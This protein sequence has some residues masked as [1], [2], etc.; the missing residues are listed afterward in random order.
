MPKQTVSTPPEALLTILQA[1]ESARLALATA[2]PERQRLGMTAW[3]ARARFCAVGKGRFTQVVACL[4][5]AGVPR[6]SA[7]SARRAD[8]RALPAFEPAQAVA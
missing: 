3:I 1:I 2:T 8:P 4:L 5:A 7:G 6:G